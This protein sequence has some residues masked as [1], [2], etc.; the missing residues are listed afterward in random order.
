MCEVDNLKAKSSR[1]CE[2]TQIPAHVSTPVPAQGT[3]RSSC[4]VTN[5]A[6]M[7]PEVALAPD[8]S[9]WASAWR[10]A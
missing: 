4:R 6:Q 8:L 5:G 10:L 7:C 3:P 1:M 2:G 9:A